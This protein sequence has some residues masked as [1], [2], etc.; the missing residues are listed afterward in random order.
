[1]KCLYIGPKSI[2]IGLCRFAGTAPGLIGLAS[3]GLVANLVPKS[4]ITGRI[5]K[6]LP[7]HPSLA[8]QRAFD[9]VDRR[10]DGTLV[11]AGSGH[12][13]RGCD[14]DRGKPGGDRGH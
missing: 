2:G 5:L 1:M 13:R 3:S 10:P 9:P 12:I 7:A 14:L 11:L 8:K 4:K 6:S